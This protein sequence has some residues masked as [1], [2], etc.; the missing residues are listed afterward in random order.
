[1]ID[2]E[3]ICSIDEFEAALR[4]EFL[5]PDQQ[6][7][8]RAALRACKQS[9]DVEE[10]D[11][12][13]L[14]NGVFV[15][16]CE[17]ESPCA[18]SESEGP[19]EFEMGDLP[20]ERSVI[21]T[22]VCAMEL[23]L[24]KVQVEGNDLLFVEALVQEKR[25]KMLVDSGATHSIVR[26]D[27]LA[28]PAGTQ[29]E[30][31]QARDF[32]EGCRRLP[33][34]SSRSFHLDA[35]AEDG[36]MKPDGDV[37]NLVREFADYLREELPEGLPPERDIEHSVQLK[38]D[39]ERSSSPWVSNV[40]SV[41]KRDPVTGELPTKI[42]WVRGCDPS[43]PVRWVVDYRYVNSATNIPPIPIPRI[44]EVFDRLAGAHV[45]TL[46]DLASGYHQIRMAFDS[47]QYT[48][49][50]AG[51][52]IYQWCVAPMGVA[53]LTGTWSRLMRRILES[54]ELSAFAVV[55]RDDICVFSKNRSDHL[56]HLRHVFEV[57]RSEQLY[58]R[59]S[60]CHFAQPQIRF[61][62]HIVS[63]ERV[64]VDPNKTAA[65]ANWAHPQS[66]KGLQRFLGLTGYYRRFVRSY[67]DLVLPLS[68]LLKSTTEWKWGSEQEFAFNT[69]KKTL[70][71]APILRLPD[72]YSPFQV[73]TDALKTCIG[74]VLRQQVD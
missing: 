44:D 5:P 64:R 49:F 45:F 27:L 50:R 31:I 40:F 29:E 41:P 65:I 36:K 37:A 32:E 43:K 14:V 73:T 20:K 59:P 35:V 13:F 69:I 63:G 16:Q 4:D 17:S 34:G 56:Q 30:S 23:R 70:I 60:K 42:Q 48:A 58:A 72:M 53:G 74:G 11:S 54:K 33:R 10:Y 61:L 8:L 25:L 18:K 21:D 19:V 9:T 68:E 6:H 28:A 62:G 15:E 52:E 24:D 55:Y 51:S 39:I 3:P 12:R 47:R 71:S 1:M 38:Q 2:N 67:A 7:R 57:L 66:V 26:R 22:S 46:I